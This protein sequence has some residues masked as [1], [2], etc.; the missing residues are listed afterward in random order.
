M[1]GEWWRLACMSLRAVAV[2]SNARI[3]KDFIWLRVKFV[4]IILKI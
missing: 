2:E 3:V 1:I 4:E